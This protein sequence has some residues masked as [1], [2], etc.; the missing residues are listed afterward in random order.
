MI[1]HWPALHKWNFGYFEQICGYRRAP[2]EQ[3]ARYTDADWS[4]KI[5]T[6]SEFLEAASESQKY[7]LAQHDLLQQVP[8]LKEDIDEPSDLAFAKSRAEGN[9]QSAV[10]IGPCGTHTPSHTDP[11]PNLYCQVAG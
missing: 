7:Y 2:I 5:M 3:G 1:S 11:Q 4:Q 10:W 9:V 8:I 6:F